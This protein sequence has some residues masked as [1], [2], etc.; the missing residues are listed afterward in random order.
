MRQSNPIPGMRWQANGYDDCVASTKYNL[1]CRIHDLPMTPW[2][3]D[4]KKP[5]AV[6]EHV[7]IEIPYGAL[8]PRNMENL[9]VAG[10]CLGAEREVMG[11]C[12]VM[13]PCAGM[14]QA[15]GLAA[16][17]AMKTGS[18]AHVSV[19]QLRELLQESGCIGAL[20]DEGIIG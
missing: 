10:R 3:G 1:I 12:R 20:S 15:A 14:G 5:N 16:G 18:F 7:W 9:I 2:M 13:G 4:A 8:L 17:L 6:R 11:A 19:R